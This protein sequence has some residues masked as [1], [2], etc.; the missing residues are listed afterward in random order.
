MQGE[1]REAAKL[2]QELLR[3]SVGAG[4]FAT[5][6]SVPRKSWTTN[7]RTIS[8]RV[9]FRIAKPRR[10]RSSWRQLARDWDG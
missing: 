2:F 8:L 7:K 1:K 5:M 3:Q 9:D 6:W 10:A 4:R